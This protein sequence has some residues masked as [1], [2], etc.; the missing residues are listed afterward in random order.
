MKHNTLQRWARRL[1]LEL[2]DCDTVDEMLS[3]GQYKELGK[4]AQGR[5]VR[6]VVDGEAWVL[7]YVSRKLTD[8]FKAE[9]TA[10]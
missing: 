3:R 8:D 1:G 10:M 9:V 5:A 2:R 4:G 6:L 7:K